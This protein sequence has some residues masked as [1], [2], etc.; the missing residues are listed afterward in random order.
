MF[1][2]YFEHIRL[3]WG[4]DRI[5]RD[6]HWK[7]TR[8]ALLLSVPYASGIFV[9]D[10]SVGSECGLTRYHTHCRQM[11]VTRNGSEKVRLNLTIKHFPF[12]FQNGSDNRSAWSSLPNMS[13]EEHNASAVPRKRN[14]WRSNPAEVLSAVSPSSAFVPPERVVKRQARQR[15]NTLAHIHAAPPLIFPLEP[16]WWMNST[17][18]RSSYNR[19]YL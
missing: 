12:F 4:A 16:S 11:T 17:T 18:C 3:R 6:K 7:M 2:I 19:S 10:V 9:L 1:T 8:Y 14:A 15:I 5:E 13:N